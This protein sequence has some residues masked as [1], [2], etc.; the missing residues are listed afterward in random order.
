MIPLIRHT[1]AVTSQSHVNEAVNNI[2]LLSLDIAWRIVTILYQWK[3]LN[4][5]FRNLFRSQVDLRSIVLTSVQSV[6]WRLFSNSAIFFRLSDFRSIVIQSFLSA[7]TLFWYFISFLTNYVWG[8]ELKRVIFS[9]SL[10]F[11]SGFSNLLFSK[12]CQKPKNFRKI[13]I[14]K[15][16]N[17]QAITP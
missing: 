2:L 1:P 7:F 15:N 13:L 4:I 11:E 16:K 8:K 12:F 10:L 17:F 3:Q 5:V 9:N 14:K 6:H